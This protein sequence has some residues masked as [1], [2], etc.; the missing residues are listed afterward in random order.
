MF[1]NAVKWKAVICMYF[2]DKPT[3]YITSD[4]EKWSPATLS[5]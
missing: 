1:F 4:P 5:A 2:C 3:V